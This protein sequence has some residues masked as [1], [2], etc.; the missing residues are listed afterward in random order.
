M[1]CS[2]HF[3]LLEDDRFLVTVYHPVEKDLR[4][5][6]KD[7]INGPGHQNVIKEIKFQDIDDLTV[8]PNLQNIVVY[9]N[10]T[11]AD[12]KVRNMVSSYDKDL[13][14]L[15]ADTEMEESVASLTKSISYDGTYLI[16]DRGLLKSA[17]TGSTIMDFMALDS[18]MKTP[19][20]FLINYRDTIMVNSSEKLYGIAY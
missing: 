13:K 2:K 20:N 12:G 18:K 14:S 19:Y 6:L 9:H 16:D 15:D 17:G 8:S 4:L 10:V 3:E 5:Q 1:V 11:S 7:N